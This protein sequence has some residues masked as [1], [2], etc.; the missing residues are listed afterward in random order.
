MGMSFKSLCECLIE[1]TLTFITF[2]KTKKKVGTIF[3]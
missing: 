1:V 2:K 3:D